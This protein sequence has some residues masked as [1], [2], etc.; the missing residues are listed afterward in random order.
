[1]DELKRIHSIAT[2]ETEMMMEWLFTI[3]QQ[4][5]F[6]DEAKEWREKTTNNAFHDFIRFFTDRDKRVRRLAKLRPKAAADAGYNSV[7]NIRNANLD[8][9]MTDKINDGLTALSL[10]M[11]EYL[12]QAVAAK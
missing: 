3:E 8:E 6:E 1:M 11:E 4:T 12:H 9:R 10:M 7:T 2:S 5:Y